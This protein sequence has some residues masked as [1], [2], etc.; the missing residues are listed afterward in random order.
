MAVDRWFFG[1][2]AE[3]TPESARRALYAST[4]GAEG[5]G[6]INDLKVL[7]LAVPG[8][9]VRVSI[10]SAL[11][12]SRY[13]G[14]ETQTY[15]GTVYEQETVSTTPTGS[16]GGRNDLVVMRVEDPY[17]AGSPYSPPSEPERATAPYIHIRVIS[18]VPA[19]TKRLQDVPGYQNDT[20]I[21]LARIVFP[22]STGTVTSAMIVDLREMAQPRRT[23]VVFARPRVADDDTTQR[24]LNGTMAN[25]GEFFPG[26]GGAPN[27]FQVDIPSW[28]THMIIDA[29]WMSIYYGKNKNPYG[30]YWVE[31]GDEY[32]NH[33]WP[34]KRQY[35]FA[36]QEFNFNAPLTNDER[37]ANWLLMDTRSV[38]TKLRGKKATFV[39]KAGLSNSPGANSVWMNWSGGLG[40]RITFSE[41]LIDPNI[42]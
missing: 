18:G 1:G 26:G 42:L 14:G 32:R 36:T 37:T 23:E 8:A 4:S 30:R 34:N 2:G 38:P 12:R 9:G 3:H 7:P 33:T 13:V 19:G 22:A 17:A 41:G 40:M 39:F 28:A 10:G 6:A 15:M 29:S 24:F 20:A 5:V 27:E 31:Y 16:G 11:I 35:E 21:A 25:G